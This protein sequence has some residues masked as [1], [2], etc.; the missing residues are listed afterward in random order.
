MSHRETITEITLDGDGVSVE[1]VVTQDPRTDLYHGSVAIWTPDSGSPETE[2]ILGE[3]SQ[4]KIERDIFRRAHELG[5]RVHGDSAIWW[6]EVDP[7]VRLDK[8]ADPIEDARE[9]IS[10]EEA[11]EIYR[12][13]PDL[14]YAVLTDQER[15]VEVWIGEDPVTVT[16][17]AA[18]VLRSQPGYVDS[19]PLAL[20][21][22]ESGGVRLYVVVDGELMDASLRDIEDREVLDLLDE[23]GEEA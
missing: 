10:L 9:G 21:R 16:G 4:S 15:G 17:P 3:R 22:T 23:H 19:R 18:D 11:R 13:D 6:A 20:A 5:I 14:I 2:E 12:D 7:E 1:G 8:D